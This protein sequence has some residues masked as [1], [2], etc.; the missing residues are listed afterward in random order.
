MNFKI[1]STSLFTLVLLVFFGHTAKAQNDKQWTKDGFHYYDLDNGNIMIYDARDAGKA[2]TLLNK[3]KLGL[4]K[5]DTLQIRRFTVSEDG[6]KILINNNTKKVWRQDT[7]GDYWLYNLHTNKLKQIG[8]ARPTSSLMFAKL[9]PD[10]N[11]VAYVSEHNVFVEDIATGIAKQLTTDGAKRLIN[12]TF[13]WAYEE[14]F[15][16]RDG[17]RWSPDSRSI[18]YWQIDA[19]KIRNYLMLNTTD[20]V[21]SHVVPVEYPVSG[22]DPSMCRIGVVNIATA[23][24][25]WMKVPGD[26]IQHYIPRMEWAGNAGEIIIQQLNRPQNESKIF[27]CNTATGTARL[28]YT[29]ADKAW[30]EVKDEPIGWD[31]VSN[32]KSFIWASEKDGWKHLYRVDRDGKETLLT[33]GNYDVVSL[34]LIDEAGGYVYFIAS[35]ENPMQR[36]LYRV[37]LNGSSATADRVTP[38]DQPGTH[39]YEVSPNGK[40][41]IHNFSN[42]YTKPVSEVINI[43]QHQHISGDMIKLDAAAAKN[44]TEFFKVKTTDGVELDGW[45]VKPTNFDASKKYPVVFMVYGE[46]ASQTVTDTYGVSRN[47]LYKGNMADDGYIYLS[48]DNRGAPAPRGREWRKSIY[49]NIGIIN[50][51]DQAMAAKEIL[52]WPYVD[53]SRVAV[54]G[55]SGGGSSTLNLLF[56]YPEIYKTGIAIAA[57]GNQL[58]YDNIYQERYM[59][60]PVDAAGRAPF[61]KGSPITYAKNLKGNLLY[62]HGTGDDNVHYDNAEM[63]INQLIKYNR[64]FQMMA[65]PNRTHAINEG[66]GTTEHL[67]TLYTQYLKEHCPPGGR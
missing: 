58:T 39:N 52:K 20:S 2:T 21:Y 67:R 35:P 40:L 7:R 38:V 53:S 22:T 1:Y 32:N 6:Q 29:D 5:N 9:S 8:A 24:T 17:F 55:W 4:K 41:A 23:K 66:E 48:V 15:D 37:S 43:P 46:P 59:G 47:R 12:G 54:W 57:V 14:E 49:K 10:G 18:A 60:V 36:Y 45:M 34:S 42:V 61:I 3:S 25:L 50:I 51:R 56:Q 65:Y 31:W 28:I 44:K 33:K 64:Q 16:C 63:L 30:V 62:I 11:K 26:A 27:I 13:D 19:T